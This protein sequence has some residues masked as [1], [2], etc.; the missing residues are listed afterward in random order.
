MPS[1]STTPQRLVANLS[2]SLTSQVQLF[3]TAQAMLYG[4]ESVYL[5][6]TQNITAY[7]LTAWQVP[8]EM[9]WKLL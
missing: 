3:A 6:A 1:T 9:E 8:E 2:T 4:G 5:S 7:H